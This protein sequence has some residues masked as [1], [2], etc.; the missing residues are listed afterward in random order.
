M[1]NVYIYLECDPRCYPRLLVTKV[2]ANS[3]L[4][5]TS[6]FNIFICC[7]ELALSCA[8]LQNIAVMQVGYCKTLLL[9][10]FSFLLKNVCLTRIPS[11]CRS[12]LFV[13]ER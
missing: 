11:V 4:L 13:L 2:E 9:A 12:V 6:S 10:V 1:L 8:C 7:F 5:G 3:S